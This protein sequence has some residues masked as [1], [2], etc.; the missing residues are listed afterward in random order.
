MFTGI[1]QE[2]AEVVAI[3]RREGITRLEIALSQARREGLVGGA[4]VAINGTC[5]TVARQTPA[6]V[7]FDVIAETLEH[8]NLGR[9]E[10][11]QQVNVERSATFADEIGGHRVSGH[12]STTAQIVAIAEDEAN[13]VMRFSVPRQ[14]L[15]LLFHKGFVALDGASLTLSAVDREAGCIEVSLI[16]ETLA[17]TTLG[18]RR[19]G[20]E[21][22]LEVDAETQAVV[23][24]VERL[25]ADP[26]WRRQLMSL[27]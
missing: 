25:F 17:R 21:V 9:L 13:R 23:E 20:D 15:R 8:T 24:T 18:F 12:V 2:L 16:P 3:S 26:Q 5:L 10:V 19:P 7:G 6:A 4:S 11:G 1:V 27:A 22:N 14:W